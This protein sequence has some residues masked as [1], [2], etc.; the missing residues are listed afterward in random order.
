MHVHHL[1]HCITV[2]QRSLASL[3]ADLKSLYSSINHL[4]IDVDCHCHAD[5][6]VYNHSIS[7]PDLSV[8]DHTL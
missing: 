1:S 5:P 8:P 3:K 2:E 4:F 6:S 7:V